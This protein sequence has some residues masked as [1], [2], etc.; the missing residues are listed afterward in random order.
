MT[1]IV[2][3]YRRR[4]DNLEAVLVLEHTAKAAAI[5]C[6]GEVNEERDRGVDRYTTVSV[7][8]VKG[9]LVAKVNDYIVRRRDG[10]F[11][12]M[13][14]AEFEAEYEN[15]GV[16]ARDVDVRADQDARLKAVV[17]DDFT[18]AQKF[19][20]HYVARGQHPFANER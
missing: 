5:W 12:V 2:Q 20:P 8:N 7:P 9:V 1:D 11:S 17:G 3:R 6:G 18:L 10:K 13:P 4:P 14:M 15:V 19:T 16:M